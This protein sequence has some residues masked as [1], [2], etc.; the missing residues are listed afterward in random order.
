M[1]IRRLLA[2]MLTSLC[3]CAAPPDASA[4]VPDEPFAD[5]G[6]ATIA[7]F[8]LAQ[9]HDYFTPFPLEL[10]GSWQPSPHMLWTFKTTGVNTICLFAPE[11]DS[12]QDAALMAGLTTAYDELHASLSAGPALVGATFVELDGD[13]MLFAGDDDYR[14]RH[15]LTGGIAVEGQFFITPISAFSVGLT[16]PAN[17]NFERPFAAVLLAIRIGRLR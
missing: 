15:V 3:V 8:G 1:G 12:V 4:Q 13:P 5:R 7:A 9:T 2:A 6:W 16:A 11:C 17:L 10:G 14:I